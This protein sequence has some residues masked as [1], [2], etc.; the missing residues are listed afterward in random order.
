MGFSFFGEKRKNKKHDTNTVKIVHKHHRPKDKTKVVEKKMYVDRK[1]P[2]RSGL[3]IGKAIGSVGRVGTKVGSGVVGLARKGYEVSKSQ[4]HDPMS[5][6]S[7]YGAPVKYKDRGERMEKLQLGFPNSAATKRMKKTGFSF[8]LALLL[9]SVV[10]SPGVIAAAPSQDD[11][12]YETGDGEG[13]MLSCFI[14]LVYSV[15]IGMVLEHP[16]A[17]IYVILGLGTILVFLAF[18][19][20]VSGAVFKAVNR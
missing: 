14:Y 6:D 5:R 20:I 7:P 8:L 13:E 4:K 17:I 9:V 15:S 16:L 12:G 11:C 19:A 1:Q 10:L 18:S 3:G 2:K